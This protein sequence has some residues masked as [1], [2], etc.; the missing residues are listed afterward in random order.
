M[1]RWEVILSI[2][3]GVLVNEVTDISPWLAKRLVQ[4]SAYRWA[5]DPAIAAVYAEEW[6]SILEDRP[7]KLL[8][9]LTAIQF[10]VGAIG[11]AAP[12]SVAAIVRNAY[13]RTRKTKSTIRNITYI[14]NAY[15]RLRRKR[16]TASTA[17][18][19]EISHTHRRPPSPT[20][21][22]SDSS[23]WLL[24]EKRAMQDPCTVGYIGLKIFNPVGAGK[25]D[26]VI[27]AAQIILR[28][29]RDGER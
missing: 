21:Q 2:T 4:W 23:Y 24:G 7:G 25:S 20:R 26:T 10:T 8:K 5:S 18:P 29:E 14:R 16:H 22:F 9:L 12:R 15:Q 19:S 27:G 6:S 3:L 13:L 1:N 17:R 11:R 28:S